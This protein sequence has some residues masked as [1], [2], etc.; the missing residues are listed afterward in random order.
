MT[1]LLAIGASG[2]R[3]YRAALAVT[4]DNVANAQ[5]VGYARR[6]VRLSEVAISSAPDFRYRNR[7]RFDGVDVAATVRAADAWR[8]G[9]ARLASSAY[10][11]SITIARW[12]VTTENALPD[13]ETGT[14]SSLARMFSAGDALAADPTSRAPRAAF[15]A[16]IDE[17]AVSIRANA[18]DLNNTATGIASEAQGSVSALNADLT[19][20][21]DVNLAIR[22]TGI[23]TTANVEL[24]DQRDRLIDAVAARA[25]VTVQIA[26]DGSATVTRGGVPLVDLGDAAT[27]A[28]TVAADGRLSFS[29]SFNAVTSSFAPLGGSI[30]GLLA[31]A[32]T[33]ATRRSALDTLASDLAS[34][35]NSWH[36]GGRTSANAGGAALLDASGGAIALAALVTDPAQVAAGDAGGIT[37]GNALGLASVRAASGAENQWAALASAQAQTTA[38][39]RA[40]ET[41]TTARKDIADAARD[42][43]EGV[44]L[45]REAADLLRFQQAYEASARVIQIA[46]ET[47][48]TILRLF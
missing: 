31:A 30:A 15:L 48:D 11:R 40:D 16:S 7:E 21:A 8:T 18:A 28:V 41:R 38:S 4:G 22:R 25:D 2:L 45:D 32:D 3:A 39:A 26:A 14:G 34:A 6:T 20:L 35:L 23:G 43:V 5:T 19:A 47:I 33:V 36:A 46:K 24:A 42:A 1:D 37:N 9:D 44:D 17:A 29:Q 12:A 27:I 13:G 10:S